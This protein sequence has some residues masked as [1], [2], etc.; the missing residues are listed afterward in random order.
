MN[1]IIKT[2]KGEFLRMLQRQN[3]KIDK[4]MGAKFLGNNHILRYYFD[5]LTGYS[6]LID[7]ILNTITLNYFANSLL[8]VC[9]KKSHS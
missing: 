2:T 7:R 4:V 1:F 5:K 8:A 3:F 9:H 6:T